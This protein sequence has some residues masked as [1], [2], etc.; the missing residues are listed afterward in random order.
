MRLFISLSAAVVLALVALAGCVSNESQPARQGRNAP[1]AGQGQS[2]ANSPLTQSSQPAPGDG[3]RRITTIELRDALA[4]GS[5]V[6]I[7]T[8]GEV[9]Y[10]QS[11]IKGAISMPIESVLARA[12]ELPH[13]KLIVAYCS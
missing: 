12:G 9:P 6:I 8:R 7:D 1:L 2:S 4:K 3:V 13:D 5:A 10:K 11:H